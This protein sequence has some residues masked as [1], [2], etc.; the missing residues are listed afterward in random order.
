MF[1][2]VMLLSWQNYPVEFILRT[3]KFYNTV[4]FYHNFFKESKK[5]KWMI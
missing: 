4:E 2:Y 5:F 1:R 3:I